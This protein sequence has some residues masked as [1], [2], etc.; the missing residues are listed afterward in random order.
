MVAELETATRGMAQ[1]MMIPKE[2]GH[3]QQSL[4]VPS[5]HTILG[6]LDGFCCWLDCDF[7]NTETKEIMP[8]LF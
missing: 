3:G 6:G 4:L 5:G 1:A 2:L 8:K 7:K